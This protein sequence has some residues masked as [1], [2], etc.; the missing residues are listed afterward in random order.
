MM[1]A[2]QWENR[3][4]AILDF[5][6]QRGHILYFDDLLG[7]FFAGIS[8]SS[9]LNVAQVLRPYI[10][11]GEIRILAEITPESFRVLQE[12]RSRLC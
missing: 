6:K 2:G 11:R 3:L 1:Y 12:P 7:L 4:L 9:N 8:A 10:E 5:A